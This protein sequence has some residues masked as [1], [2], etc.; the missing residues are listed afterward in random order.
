MTHLYA[1]KQKNWK[2]TLSL[3]LVVIVV[4]SL[5]SLF[6]CLR[7][8]PRLP[9]RSF[10]FT[11]RQGWGISRVAEEL[12]KENL[13]PTKICTLLVLLPQS[14]GIKAGT[15]RLSQGESRLH[16]L[17]R[18]LHAEYGDVY[19]KITF[20]EGGTIEDYAEILAK[21]RIARDPQILL[22]K[23]VE[24]YFYP[25]TYALAP[26]EGVD[27]LLMMVEKRFK[28]VFD[29]A[30][31][32]GSTSLSD[33]DAVILASLIEKEAGRSLEEKRIIAGILL[34]RLEKGVP[35]Q[36]DAP[37]LYERDKG[38]AQLTNGD[39]QQDS[40]YNTYTRKGLPKTAIGNPGRDALYAVFHPLQTP[41]WFYLHGK[42]GNIHY[43]RT[44]AEH[45]KNKRKYLR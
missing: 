41:Y 17:Q 9:G 14:E 4:F 6:I 3:S 38:S 16:I 13:F 2:K 1:E 5:L 10:L 27:T 24:G 18:F 36:V 44:Y 23:A 7:S 28:E 25:D 29:E 26:G 33:R 11:I 22:S 42:D 12:S 8:S 20:P 19:E 15:Y 39:L 31:R 30:K 40:P 32:G 37:F 34:K 35:L 21:R 45:L 43:A